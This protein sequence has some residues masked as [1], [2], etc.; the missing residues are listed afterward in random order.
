MHAPRALPA[1]DPGGVRTGVGWRVPEHSE[2]YDTSGVTLSKVATIIEFPAVPARVTVDMIESESSRY[3][4]A[5]STI[6]S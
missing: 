1:W 4:A 3:L 6:A 5:F 2:L